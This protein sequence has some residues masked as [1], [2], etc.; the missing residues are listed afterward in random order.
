MPAAFMSADVVKIYDKGLT[1]TSLSTGERVHESDEI[2]SDTFNAMTLEH[3]LYSSGAL[4]WRNKDF[5]RRH[6][7]CLPNKKGNDICCLIFVEF[8]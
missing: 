6:R 2:L 3:V 4:D 5:T 8:S 1:V 7:I